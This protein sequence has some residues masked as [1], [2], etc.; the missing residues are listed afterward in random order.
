M[1]HEILKLITQI[2]QSE[3]ETLAGRVNLACC[4]LAV[5]VFCQ[6]HRLEVIRAIVLTLAGRS[7]GQPGATELVVAIP[8]LLIPI[9]PLLCLALR[10]PPPDD[11]LDSWLSEL[12]LD[13]PE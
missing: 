2:W 11:E 6:Y 7:L 8:L 4:V 5:L 3:K 9:C 12:D 13:D 10:S 1:G